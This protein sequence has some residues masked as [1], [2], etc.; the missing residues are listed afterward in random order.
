M[1]GQ[2]KE[3]ARELFNKSLQEGKQITL[4]SEG[5][6]MEP[7]LSAGDEITFAGRKRFKFADLLVCRKDSTLFVH[8]F[9]CKIRRDN[10]T[11]LVLKADARWKPDAPID[12]EAAVGVV[13]KIKRDGRLIALDTFGGRLKSIASFFCCFPKFDA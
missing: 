4:R 3:I 9:V 5:F 7:L 13:T 8:R 1:K 11:V 12:A 2:E 6:C 10:K